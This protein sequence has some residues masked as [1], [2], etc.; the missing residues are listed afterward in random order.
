MQTL[1][2]EDSI[3]QGG[4]I[5]AVVTLHIIRIIGS[6]CDA[7]D[8]RFQII[9][10]DNE[11]HCGAF[12]ALRGGFTCVGVFLPELLSMILAILA[13]T[14]DDD[15]DSA[16]SVYLRFVSVMFAYAMSGLSDLFWC[17][18]DDDF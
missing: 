4:A 14:V 16:R 2:S 8:G 15:L 10:A 11:V 12:T 17:C 18:A 1:Y 9:T 3:P 7:R 5:A 13:L 6:F